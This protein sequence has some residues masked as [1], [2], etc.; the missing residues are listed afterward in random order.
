MMRYATRTVFAAKDFEG[1]IREGADELKR[2]GLVVMPTETVYG[3]G[4]NAFSA[5]AVK[6]IFLAKGRPQD[7]PLIVHIADAAQVKDVAK[8]VSATARALMKAF[9]P[10]PISIIVKKSDAIPSEVSAGLETVAVRMPD[11]DIARGIIA[12]AGVPVAAPSANTSGRPSPTLAMHAY[13]DLCGRVPLII[14]GGPCAVGVESTVVDATG[15]VPVILRPGDITPEMIV[16]AVGKV[17]VHPS[18]LGELKQ[19]EICA[20][21]GMKYKHY[22]PDARVI[23]LKGAKKEVAKTIN[24]MYH[25]GKA[26]GK[27][28][29]VLCLDDCAG[30]YPD[31]KNVVL[32][33]ADA[34]SA[35]AAL[36]R[37][38]REMDEQ[39]F[40]LVLFHAQED[41]MGLAVMNRI[42][43]AAGHEVITAKEEKL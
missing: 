23:V 3:L 20:S 4:A 25:N 35:E 22:S 26:Q 6:N 32:L 2:G 37:V 14:D 40:K 13:E 9:W 17:R 27:K 21:P 31:V 43:R 24:T 36:F 38:L 34:H 15:D 29:A 11:N 5:E 33:G 1:A 30:L 18:V 7:N 28:T 42:I 8:E 41:K 39:N 10:G 12:L 19:D 16:Q